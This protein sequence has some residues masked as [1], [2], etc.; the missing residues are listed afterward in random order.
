METGFDFGTLLVAF[1]VIRRTE[2]QVDN[3]GKRPASRASS[4]ARR[5]GLQHQTRA[6]N[7]TAG[8]N[9]RK[10]QRTAGRTGSPLPALFW[11]GT[12]ADGI[13]AVAPLGAR[14][15]CLPCWRGLA[16][17]RYGLA[18]RMAGRASKPTVRGGQPARSIETQACCASVQSQ[19][20]PAAQPHNRAT[21][22]HDAAGTRARP[23][24]GNTVSGHL[25]AAQRDEL[26]TKPIEPKAAAR[27]QGSY[28]K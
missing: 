6:G 19:H 25:R 23:S 16:G 4:P 21:G 12:A 3:R 22:W 27:M 20:R 15:T 18:G 10:R 17:H 9:R 11:A 28:G 5:S 24:A 8:G 7:Q 26:G 14:A 2:D 13:R 1:V